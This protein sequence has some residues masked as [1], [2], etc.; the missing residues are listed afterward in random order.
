MVQKEKRA[1]KIISVVGFVV[2]AVACRYCS[3]WTSLNRGSE[4]R[5]TLSLSGVDW[6]YMRMNEGYLMSAML[7]DERSKDMGHSKIGM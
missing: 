1:Q 7:H 6:D 3:Q 5:L 2:T 4:T